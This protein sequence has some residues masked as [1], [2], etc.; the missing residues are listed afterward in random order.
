[1]REFGKN[2]GRLRGARGG[3]ENPSLISLFQRETP[4]PGNRAFKRG[5]GGSEYPSLISLFQRETPIPGNRAFKRGEGFYE[6][7]SQ[8]PPYQVR[9]RLFFKGR[10]QY[11]GTGRLRGVKGVTKIPLNLPRIKYGAGSL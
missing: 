10:R 7:P 3:S 1:M 2:T 4:I 9:G 5:E 6:N 8:S 11:P